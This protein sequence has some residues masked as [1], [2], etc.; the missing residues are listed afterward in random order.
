MFWQEAFNH[1]PAKLL[2][3]VLMLWKPNAKSYFL[4]L[5]GIIIL[6]V[7]EDPGWRF[8]ISESI[9]WSP[10]PVDRLLL[11]LYASSLGDQKEM[12]CVHISTSLFIAKRKLWRRFLSLPFL[13]IGDGV[14]IFQVVFLDVLALTVKIIMLNSWLDS[15][16]HHYREK[17]HTVEQVIEVYCFVWLRIFC[18]SFW[19]LSQPYWN[20]KAQLY[21]SIFQRVNFDC[22]TSAS[23]V[24]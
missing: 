21:A 17:E 1:R 15:R 6:C 5:I 12:S 2:I 19:Y 10:D 4:L 13:G 18:C 9:D 14:N 24:C 7:D 11:T 23:W 22:T 3:S 8:L 16:M 20:D